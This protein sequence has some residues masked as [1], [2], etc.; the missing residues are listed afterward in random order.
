MCKNYFIFVGM[1]TKKQHLLVVSIPPT[2]KELLDAIEANA[3]KE[4]VSVSH[5][6]RTLLYSILKDKPKVG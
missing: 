3:K 1:E 4:K 5:Y 6:T 2:H